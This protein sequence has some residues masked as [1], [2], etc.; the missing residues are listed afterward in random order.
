MSVS[1]RTF[2]L[3]DGTVEPRAL[4]QALL[5]LVRALAFWA[6]IVLPLTYVPLLVTGLE[7]VSMAVAFV[8]LVAVNVCALV[9]GQP[10]G[11]R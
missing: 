5:T 9:L 11:Q 10:Y 4:P 2:R 6:A 1:D 8:C 7:S 3:P